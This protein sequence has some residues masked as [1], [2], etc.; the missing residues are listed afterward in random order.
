MNI[1]AVDTSIQTLTVAVKTDTVLKVNTPS[2]Q[3]FQHSER[4]MPEIIRLCED[5]GIGISDLN[6]LIC[7]R[8]PGS[9]TGLRIGMAALKGMAFGLDVPLVS[10]STLEVWAEKI[11]NHGKTI[12]PV[13]DARKQRFYISTFETS[14]GNLKRIMPDT[15]GTAENLRAVLSSC[16]EITV[17]GPDAEIFAPE[18]RDVFGNMKN[19]TV[20]GTDTCGLGEALIK[21]GLEKYKTEGADNIGQGP[22]YLRKSDAEEALEAR[23]KREK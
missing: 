22:V 12:V 21:T 15:D 18:L 17:T 19:I 11:K 23:L 16:N 14:D 9:F 10:V 6:L 20:C 8:G 4:L 3:S 13:I 1:L 5:A 7:T 2:V